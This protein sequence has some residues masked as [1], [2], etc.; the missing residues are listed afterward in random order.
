MFNVC[1]GCGALRADKIIDEGSG[2]AVCPECGHRHPFVRAPL[3][4]VSGASGS[5][6]STV[7]R[8]IQQG[9]L[10]GDAVVFEGDILWAP[11]FEK[12]PGLFF[13]TWLRVC[14]NTAQS[15]RP[16]VLFGAGTGVPENVEPCIERRYFSTLHYLALTCDDEVLAERLRKR[17]AW[18]QSGGDAY[19]ADHVAF[20]RWFKEQG[21][22]GT[23]PID[24]IDTTSESVDET[25]AHVV[26]WIS[27]RLGRSR[28]G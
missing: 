7:C 2:E 18:R 3:V 25:A 17:P 1:D 23:P 13:E 26:K 27:A 16:V 22:R 10:L 19:V 28:G 4:L 24:L 20:N 5:G 8:R 12:A 21:R 15:G 6:K 14:K 9:A 11:H